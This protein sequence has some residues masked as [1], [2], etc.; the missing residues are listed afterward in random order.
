MSQATTRCT[1]QCLT[2]PSTNSGIAIR[3]CYCA[4]FFSYSGHHCFSKRLADN[5]TQVVVWS[6]GAGAMGYVSLHSDGSVQCAQRRKRRRWTAPL[7]LVEAGGA[8]YLLYD[9]QSKALLAAGRSGLSSVFV[10]SADASVAP[11]TECSAWKLKAMIT[12]PTTTQL[13]ADLGTRLRSGGVCVRL[14][15]ALCPVV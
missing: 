7:Q 12:L 6:T 13:G 3:H 5:V 11:G 9:D 2:A 10:L 8:T 1:L 4:C 14:P 15:S